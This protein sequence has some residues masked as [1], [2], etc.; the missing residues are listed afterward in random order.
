ML[1]CDFLFTLCTRDR[2]CSAHP[3]F[4]A[5]SLCRGTTKR[6]PRASP[7]A[8]TRT[9][10]C[11]LKSETPSV[12][13]RPHIAEQEPRDLP[14]LDFLTAFGDAVATVVAVDVLERLVARIAHAAMDL[15]G[16]VGS[17]AAQPVSPE[18]AHR[19]PVGQRV[20]DLRLGQ[21]VHLPGGL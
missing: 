17:L 9:C 15:H 16:A 2:G 19:N 10:I 8:R 4:P 7:A 14:L 12:L 21:L 13:S 3:A 11:C 20:L 18:I 5:P 1:V 6:K